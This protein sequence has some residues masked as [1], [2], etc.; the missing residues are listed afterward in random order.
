[1]VNNMINKIFFKDEVYEIILTPE[2]VKKLVYQGILTKLT[3]DD[4]TEQILTD[5]S[6][7]IEI[8]ED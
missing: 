1:M 3:E 5:V 2:T 8:L 7:N 6:S 4:T